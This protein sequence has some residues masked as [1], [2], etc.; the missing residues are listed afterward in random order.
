MTG[1][2]YLKMTTLKAFKYRIYPNKSQQVLLNKT[3]GCVR[4]VWNHNVEVF[5]KYD[6]NL[7]KQ[8]E[9]LTS[10]QLRQ[11]FEWMNEVSA[12]ALQQKEMDF[13]T[14]QKNY[15]SRTRKKIRATCF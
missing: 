3:F 2:A 11:K 5:N 7:S 1:R 12:A 13:K 10:T 4:V 9:S 14:F 6:N 8:E 15:F